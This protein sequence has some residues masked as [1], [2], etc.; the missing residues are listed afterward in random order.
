MVGYPNVPFITSNKNLASNV[1][2]F[3]PSLFSCK[4]FF[5]FNSSLVWLCRHSLPRGFQLL[6]FSAA[7]PA[8]G[9]KD[10]MTIT[11]NV[12][13]GCLRLYVRLFRHTWNQWIGFDPS[14]AKPQEVFLAS[15]DDTTADVSSERFI[16]QF[17]HCLHISKLAQA[18]PVS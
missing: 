8:L 18:R 1:S 5:V 13:R 3:R 15:V 14:T 10:C 2:F 4:Y 17:N 12:L 9:D 6:T 7:G 11:W 16:L